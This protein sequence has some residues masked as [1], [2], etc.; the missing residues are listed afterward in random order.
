M[1]KHPANVGAGAAG[2]LPHDLVDPPG[3]VGRHFATGFDYSHIT[4]SR[5]QAKTLFN[6]QPKARQATAERHSEIENFR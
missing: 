4:N 5:S 2:E 1:V 3:L 6:P